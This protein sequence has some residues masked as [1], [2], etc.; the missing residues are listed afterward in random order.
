[1]G[2]ARPGAR[3]EPQ[4]GRLCGEG[5][6]DSAGLSPGLTACGCGEPPG[7]LQLRGV[8]VFQE[9]QAAERWLGF[10]S[11]YIL[12]QRFVLA[13]E[14]DSQGATLAQLWA[15]QRGWRTEGLELG[16]GGRLLALASASLPPG[17]RPV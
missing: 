7:A 4:T 17:G 1:M 16:L 13:N 14:G 5:R 2:G 8:S 10:P 9:I 15:G 6:G 11:E 12:Y 3:P